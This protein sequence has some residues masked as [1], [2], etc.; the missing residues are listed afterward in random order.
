MAVVMIMSLKEDMIAV[1]K[2]GKFGR[3]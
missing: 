1:L 3:E 2:T